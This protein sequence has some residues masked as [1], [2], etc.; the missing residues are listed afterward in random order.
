[1]N[2]VGIIAE[3]NPFHNGHEYH[4]HMA[5][6]LSGADHVIVCMSASFTQRGEPAC[7]DKFARARHALLGGADMVIELP[8]PL[9]CSC[10]ER[11]AYGGVQLLSSTG[12]VDALAFGSE[13]GD[14]TMLKK[15]S[16]LDLNG[17]DM[18]AAL[19]KG[20]SYP[21]AASMVMREKGITIDASAPNDMLAIEYMRQL[22]G[23]AKRIDPIA[24]PRIGAGYNEISLDKAFASASA[25]RK[26]AAADHMDKKVLKKHIPEAVFSDI[27]HEA[28]S[29]R[30]PAALDALSPAILFALRS[31]GACG[32]AKLADVSEGLENPLYR[33][34]LSSS[35]CCEL[36][37]KV[38]TKRYTLAR[39]RRILCYSLIGTTSEM[40]QF[41]CEKTDSLYIRVLGVK[42]EK[43][44]LLSALSER[45]A[46]PVVISASD[47]E[48]LPEN[49]SR[50]LAHARRAHL[51]HA[52]S[53]PKN[54]SCI[55][56]LSHPLITV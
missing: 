30:F 4:V 10:A 5:K 51:I 42:K 32:I 29:G 25:L 53:F 33:A 55:D 15:A 17:A 48:R 54:C 27:M 20:L 22:N 34:S 31:L 13:C 38:K 39:L 37:E 3:Y 14:I 7:L 41:T 49:A 35:C 26:A 6:K 50:V 16:E 43:L 8:D 1:M 28:E 18:K 21:A 45:A 46:L 56:D 44:H 52:L 24:I 9:S 47:A 11:F 23:L 12:L 2:A 40:Q 19:S 36:L